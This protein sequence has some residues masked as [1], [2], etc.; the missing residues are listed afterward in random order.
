MTA[1]GC[2]IAPQVVATDAI[3]VGAARYFGYNA[4]SMTNETAYP[5]ELIR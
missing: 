4:G 1:M 2:D 5:I 3:S